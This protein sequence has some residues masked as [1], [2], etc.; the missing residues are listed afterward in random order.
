MT[1][2]PLYYKTSDDDTSSVDGNFIVRLGL[3]ALHVFYVNRH[4]EKLLH[5]GTRLLR[6]ARYVVVKGLNH[7]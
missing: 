1:T 6:G 2:S 7:H 3:L 4:W 5:C